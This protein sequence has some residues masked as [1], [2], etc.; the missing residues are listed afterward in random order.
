MRTESLCNDIRYYWNAFKLI[1]H[2]MICLR[3]CN[4][5][6][7]IFQPS[8]KTKFSIIGLT[9]EHIC[10]IL[11]RNLAFYDIHTPIERQLPQS[12]YNLYLHVIYITNHMLHF[13][14]HDWQTVERIWSNCV[15]FQISAAQPIKL[16]PNKSKE[17]CDGIGQ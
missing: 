9:I 17:V 14:C 13:V 11:W 4:V 3:C 10:T 16:L 12:T 15:W 7:I 8:P 2:S 1:I 5:G 6:Y